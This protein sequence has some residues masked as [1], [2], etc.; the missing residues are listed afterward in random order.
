VH[1]GRLLHG[2]EMAGTVTTKMVWHGTTVLVF[3]WDI[4]IIYHY[5]KL[6]IK[7]V[8]LSVTEHLLGGMSFHG[9]G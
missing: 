3:D 1:G 7:V 8:H 6:C 4:P 2:R 9:I 5:H